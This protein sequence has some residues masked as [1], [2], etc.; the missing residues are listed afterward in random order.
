MRFT[1]VPSDAH[2]TPAARQ[3]AHG[4]AQLE[5]AEP[6]ESEFR[7][8]LRLRVLPWTR[9]GFAALAILTL[10]LW[11]ADQ[12]Q[13]DPSLMPLSALLRLGVMLP[14]AL[15]G[16]ALTFLSRAGASPA[17][18][19]PV[20]LVGMALAAILLDW[21]VARDGGAFAFS[22]LPAVIMVGFVAMGARFWPA[23]DTGGALALAGIAAVAFAGWP[24][25]QVIAYSLVLAT[26]VAGGAAAAYAIEHAIRVA[27]LEALVIGHLGERDGLTGLFNRRMF[28]GFIG[29]VWEQ[30]IEDKS[31]I[32]LM[33][34]DV[35][36]FR[37]YNDRF[38][39]Q[40]GDE[41]IRRVAGAISAC[42]LR[43]LDF[44]ARYSGVQF[45]IVLANPDRL[46]AEEVPRRVR[47]AVAALEIP[48]PQSPNGRDVTVSVGV[49][50]TVPRAIDS[51]ERYIELAQTALREAH[52]QG[53][54]R[55]V[56]RESESSL[57]Q[58]GMFRAEVAL[59]AAREG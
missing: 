17:S 39:L 55:V 20:P 50:L 24:A 18:L 46:Y 3:L 19:T 1:L 59:A 36:N 58:S 43:P 40:A 21:H 12:L 13:L 34:I 15:F 49:A 16:L 48:H 38:G 37:H 26:V 25:N 53:G 2:D 35:D 31:L 33:L 4:F 5:F 41:C 23:L 54:D 10:L 27:W 42:A 6:L 30:S 57:V 28:D 14:L 47:E 44:C 9:A 29:R 51:L 45:A 52:D 7:K 22:G 32:V 8:T 11:I 56:A